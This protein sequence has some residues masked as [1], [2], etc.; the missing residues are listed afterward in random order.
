MVSKFGFIRFARG[1]KE[2]WSDRR[3]GLKMSVR[4]KNVLGSLMVGRYRRF[5]YQIAD[6]AKVLEYKEFAEDFHIYRRDTLTDTAVYLA[7]SETFRLP[8]PVCLAI[9]NKSVEATNEV[10]QVEATE[11]KQAA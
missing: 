7:K 2:T 3:S 6:K 1:R 8:E 11:L 4:V 10:I 9:E 5:S